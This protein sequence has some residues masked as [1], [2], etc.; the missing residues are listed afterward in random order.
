M[1]HQNSTIDQMIVNDELDWEQVFEVLFDK[2]A[3][4]LLHLATTIL[5]DPAAAEDVVQETLITAVTKLHQYQPGTNLNAWLYTI[6]VNRCRRNYRKNMVRQRLVDRLKDIL[7]Q[8]NK[9]PSPEETILKNEINTQLWKAVNMLGERHR[10]PIILRY[11]HGLSCREVA[12][13]L[14]LNEGTVRS[15]LHYG[16]QKLQGLVQRKNINIGRERKV[17]K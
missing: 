5:G 9:F 15:R 11:L 6:A 16:V 17:A 3:D 1:I 14:G 8:E 12:Q 10:L 13:I 7:K 2:Y 4:D